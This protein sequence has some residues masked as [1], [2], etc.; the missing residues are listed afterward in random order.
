MEFGL[1]LPA[2]IVEMTIVA[3]AV[4]PILV[5]SQF[6][7]QRQRLIAIASVLIMVTLA[8]HKSEE[9]TYVIAAMGAGLWY[10]AGP[11]RRWRLA[12]VLVA[13]ISLAP[14]Y[15][16][17]GGIPADLYEMLTVG[18]PFFPT[19]LLPFVLLAA[20][21]QLELWRLEVT[22]PLEDVDRNSRERVV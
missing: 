22:V 11:R 5:R 21:M 13:M 17:P 1:E 14:F 10:A 6:F 2:I 18:R 20:I 7:S 12:L 15:P 19:R 8:N 3:I 16:A 4:L 9:Q